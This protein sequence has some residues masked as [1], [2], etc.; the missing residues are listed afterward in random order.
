VDKAGE[1]VLSSWT[2]TGF[3][4]KLAGLGLMSGLLP[5]ANKAGKDHNQDHATVIVLQIVTEVKTDV[6]IISRR[7]RKRN[8]C[9]VLT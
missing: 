5:L 6:L 8:K 9:I 3:L 2:D 1:S 4:I 7:S